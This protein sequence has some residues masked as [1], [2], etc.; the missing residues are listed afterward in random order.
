MGFVD[1]ECGHGARRRSQGQRGRHVGRRLLLLLDDVFVTD[2]AEAL[3]SRSAVEA[4]PV[5]ALHRMLL[6]LIR[7]LIHFDDNDEQQPM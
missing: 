3:V 2:R 6:H 7:F 5:T 4:A 1:G